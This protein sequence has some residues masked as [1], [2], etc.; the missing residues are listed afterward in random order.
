MKK[1]Q[2][3]LSIVILTYNVESVI[4][5]CL[6]SVFGQLEKD[7]EVIVVDNN[8]SDR[9]L[10]IVSGFPVKIIK[11][12]EN[13]GFAG[14]NNLAV[15]QAGGKYILFLNPDTIV[16]KG[17]IK[18]CLDYLENYPNVGAATVKVVLGSGKLDY[19]C[20][21]GFPTPWNSLTY[22]SGL[23]ALF[24]KSKLFA[25]YTMGYK[26]F[27]EVHE[28]DAIN[29]AFFMM[30]KDLGD[31]LNWFDTDFF[32][33]GEDLD[34]CFRIKQAG[35]KIMYLPGKKI[36]HYKGSSGGHK[37][38]SKTFYSRFDVMKLFYDKHYKYVYPKIIRFLVFLG[39]D[40]RKAIQWLLG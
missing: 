30:P 16:E 17:A 39:I 13:L 5:P 21:R 35:Y 7:W 4:K 29:G 15:K 20:H 32:W 12:N 8:S 2:K 10:E 19:S 34:F 24:S 27:N 11:N 38:G 36:I 31:R 6:E 25:G 40:L 37:K 9:T 26:N 28:V 22:F 23:A 14:G 18:Y 3:R 1:Q 33:N